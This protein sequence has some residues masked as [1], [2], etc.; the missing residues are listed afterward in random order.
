MCS[1]NWTLEWARDTNAIS[2]TYTRDVGYT[3]E[4]NRVVISHGIIHG[5][6]HAA[7]VLPCPSLGAVA[8]RGQ[9]ATGQMTWLKVFRPGC[10][11]FLLKEIYVYRKEHI[12][13][14]AVSV[15]L[16]IT[17]MWNQS[18]Q[19]F[20]LLTCLSKFCKKI[21][22]FAWNLFI[23]YPGI[24]LSPDVR[25]KAKTHQNRFRLGLRPRPPRGSLQRSPRPPRW[26]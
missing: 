9:G 12:K 4:Q 10:H 2:A 23:L 18:I 15:N 17:K 5:P 7:N 19:C 1:L 25:F 3:E 24:S 16:P 11:F 20:A 22:N 26:I 6:E 13:N 21:G 14:D 8:A